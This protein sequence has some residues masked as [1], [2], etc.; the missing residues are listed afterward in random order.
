MLYGFKLDENTKWSACSDVEQTRI[1]RRIGSTDP[2]PKGKSSKVDD[3]DQQGGRTSRQNS[4]LFSR[5][6]HPVEKA[7]H[8]PAASPRWFVSPSPATTPAE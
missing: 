7:A 6:T 4:P 5:P 8:R 2:L 1:L 3:Q